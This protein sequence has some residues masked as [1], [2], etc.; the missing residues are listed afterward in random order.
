MVPFITEQ[1]WQ[2]LV[3]PTNDKAVASVHLSDF[4][5][6]DKNAINTEL[7]SQVGLTRRIVELGRASRAESGIK[8]RQP[9]GRALIAASGWAALPAQM[10]EQIADELNVI[11]LADIADA[12]G[13][14]VDISVK[15]NFKSLGAKFGGAVQEIAK[16]IAA[17]DATSLVKTLRASGTTTVADWKI[18]LDD[19][20]ITEVPKSGWMVASH[21]GESVALDLEMTPALI[22]AG[23]VREVIRFIQE[24]RKSDGFEISDRIEV[25]WN[26][27]AEISEA[28]A[29]DEARIKDEVLA[30]SM[31]QDSS[32]SFDAD[33]I[34]LAV[35][36]TKAR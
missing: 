3:I 4:P 8:I 26:A 17:S 34:G 19:L 1:V 2:E 32:L 18:A 35:K 29:S 16:A 22:T 11:N 25:L 33:E 23:N 6:S 10:R 9:L 27:N 36:L 21:E 28:I 12:D 30:L 5:V 15:A 7:G 24:R 20:V 31:V 14:L 13:D